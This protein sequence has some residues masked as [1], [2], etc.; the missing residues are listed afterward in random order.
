MK[1]RSSILAL[2]AFFVI[3]VGISACGSGVPGNAVVD[4]AGNP[5]STQAVNHWM[6]VAAKTQA[7]QQSPTQPVIVPNDPPEFNNCVALVRKDFSTLAKT[8][9]KTLRGECQQAFTSLKN[10]VLDFLI[11]AYWYQADAAKLGINVTNAQVEKTFTAEKNAQF[12]SNPSGFNTF[13]S[14]SGQTVPDLLYRFRIDAILQKLVAKHTKP[15]TQAQIQAYYNSHLSQ[16]GKQETR[17]MKVVLA[18]SQANA[19]AAK[20]ALSSGQSWATVVKKYSIDPT[21]KSTGGVLNGVTKQQEEAALSTAAFAAPANKLLGPVKGQFGW[22]VF[23]VT[24]I[25]PGTQQTLAQASPQIKQSLTTSAQ[26]AAQTA[27]D[28]TAKKHW[29]S[30]TTC[31]PAYAMSD[32]SGYKAPK[33]SSSTSSSATATTG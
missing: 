14:Q 12:A 23:E 31:R 29:L 33:S 1:V 2:G 32:C 7:A 6:Y 8:S 16:Y 30:Q 21:T 27:V 10:S 28:N 22:Y 18:S 26:T 20:K 9:T 15:V 17:S 24:K 13:L 5:I 4:V 11:K 19:L 3:A 25:T